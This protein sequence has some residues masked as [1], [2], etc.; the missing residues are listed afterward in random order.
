MN[1]RPSSLGERRRHPIPRVRQLRS[2]TNKRVHRGESR[3]TKT[4][5]SVAGTDGLSR[6]HYRFN[7]GLQSP[8]STYA[9]S[10][11]IWWSAALGLAPDLTIQGG[12]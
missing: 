8:I 10:D 12:A 5:L 3:G 6:R 7:S 9:C 11:V 2:G 4:R 1:C